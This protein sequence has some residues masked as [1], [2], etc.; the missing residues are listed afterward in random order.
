MKV[1]ISVAAVAKIFNEIAEPLIIKADCV[2]NTAVNMWY[3]SIPLEQTP[4]EEKCDPKCRA[5]PEADK[6]SKGGQVFAAL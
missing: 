6:P 4:I 2:L 3:G 5:S 1:E